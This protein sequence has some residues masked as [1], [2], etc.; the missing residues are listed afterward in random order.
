[1]NRIGHRRHNCPGNP[2][3]RVAAQDRAA[4]QLR[5]GLTPRDHR[6]FHRQQIARRPASTR[7]GHATG[8]AM[9]QA[10]QVTNGGS[11]WLTPPGSL[12]LRNFP[13]QSLQ[14]GSHFVSLMQK[15]GKPA[16]V[17]ATTFLIELTCCS[18]SDPILS[19]GCGAHFFSHALVKAC[20]PTMA[21]VA[22]CQCLSTAMT[23]PGASRSCGVHSGG[24]CMP[25][26][27][28]GARP[29]TVGFR[30]ETS[31]RHSLSHAFEHSIGCA[32]KHHD[33]VRDACMCRKPSAWGDFSWGVRPA[34]VNCWPPMFGNTDRPHCNT[35]RNIDAP[36][37]S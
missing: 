6:V 15:A 27:T 14:S 20:K 3:F 5:Q 33:A 12:H 8:R 16:V 30:T 4:V 29:W 7:P 31:I 9:P 24:L 1:M 18:P 26:H 23:T 37:D 11:D 32:A 21:H 2:D 25:L 17:G 28:A 36:P 22:T 19:R 13:A 34:D 10:G 35:Q